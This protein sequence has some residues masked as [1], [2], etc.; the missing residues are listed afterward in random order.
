[1]KKWRERI[2]WFTLSVLAQFT[3][4]PIRAQDG[5]TGIS[6]ANEMV[7]GYFDTGVSLLYAVGAVFGLV[8]A[9]KV[10]KKWVR[11]DHDTE[12]VAASWFSACIF[13]VLV[14]TVL[15]SFFGL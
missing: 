5:N 9:V 8:G 11:G 13:L 1:M 7:R 6:K 4:F 15:R 2:I 3:A 10:Y 12:A 14:A